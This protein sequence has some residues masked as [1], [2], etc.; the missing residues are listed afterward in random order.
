MGE[1]VG[2]VRAAVHWGGEL[3]TCRAGRGGGLLLVSKEGEEGG[4]GGAPVRGST[5]H[6]LRLLHTG[7]GP[8]Q[9]PWPWSACMAAATSAALGR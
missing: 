2:C 8:H 3:A 1:G 7:K 5:R 6:P 9:K 4:W